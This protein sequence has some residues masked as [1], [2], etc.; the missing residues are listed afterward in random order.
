MKG[1]DFLKHLQSLTLEGVFRLY[2]KYI[3]VI[4][5]LLWLLS[6]GGMYVVMTSSLFSSEDQEEVQLQEK[7]KEEM[8][9]PLPQTREESSEE[10]KEEQNAEEEGYVDV[11]GEVKSPNIYPIT[12]GMRVYDVIQK[13]GGLTKEA[14]DRSLNFAQRVSDQMVIIVAKKGE[15]FPPSTMPTES[16]T[17][18]DSEKINVNTA[19][20]TK[21]QEIPGIGEKRAQDIIDYRE[22]NGPFKH[23]DDLGQISGI[24][25]KTLEKIKDKVSF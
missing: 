6:L 23:L 7:M 9:K 11:K 13:A 17:Q 8:Q 24:G 10:K 1:Q 22:S 5:G 14:D 25:E 21:L 3:M 2:G 19:D 12:K 4:V 15:K 16:S 20:A 18:E